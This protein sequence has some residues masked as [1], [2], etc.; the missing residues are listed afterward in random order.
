M[1]VFW[2][3]LDEFSAFLTD[4]WPSRKL[5]FNCFQIWITDSGAV[6]ISI[7]IPEA[8]GDGLQGLDGTEAVG[9]YLNRR[10]WPFTALNSWTGSL[11]AGFKSWLELHLNRR[12][13]RFFEFVGQFSWRTR[14]IISR[15]RQYQDMVSTR[16][17]G[18]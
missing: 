15:K 5:L 6:A 8:S 16:V 13:L 10:L 17:S 7:R 3:A 1:I 2:T 11:S 14:V 4:G 18:R 9:L 12:Q